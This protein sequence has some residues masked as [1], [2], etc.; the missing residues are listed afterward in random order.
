M[1]GCGPYRGNEQSIWNEFGAV[2][3]R[4]GRNRQH[5]VP[6]EQLLPRR[7]TRTSGAAAAEKGDTY[8]TCTLSALRCAHAAVLDWYVML[9]Y[10]HGECMGGSGEVRRGACMSV[11]RRWVNGTPHMGPFTICYM[12]MMRKFR[13]NQRLFNDEIWLGI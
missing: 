2:G 1:D 10:W 9:C 3:I 12:G 13:I 11:L 4:G 5:T 8:N 7:G 6:V